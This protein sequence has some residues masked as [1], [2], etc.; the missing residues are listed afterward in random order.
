MRTVNLYLLRHG[1]TLGEAALNGHTDVAV[2]DSVQQSICAA[3]QQELPPF[4]QIVSSPLKRCHDLAQ[5]LVNAN[6]A[7]NLQ[8]EACF[9]EM[10]FGQFDGVPFDQL[11]AQW[12]VL[13]AFWQDPFHNALPGAEPQQTFYNRVNDGWQI[14]AEQ[15]TQDTLLIAHGGTIRM[16]LASVLG[17]DWQNPALFSVLQIANQSITHIK[18]TYLDQMYLQV[19]S[20]GTPLPVK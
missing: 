11:G 7:M 9:K 10:N 2:S 13:E 14:L 18:I 12:S 19:C 16:I 6:P 15:A 3:V 5:L 1:K 4:R 20:I 17:L 8:V